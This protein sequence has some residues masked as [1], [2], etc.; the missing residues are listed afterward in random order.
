MR[1]EPVAAWPEP[2]SPDALAADRA[3]AVSAALLARSLSWRRFGALGWKMALWL[4][5]AVLMAHLLGLG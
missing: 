2:A 3:P 1:S 4:S 5:G